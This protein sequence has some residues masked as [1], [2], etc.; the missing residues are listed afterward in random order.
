MISRRA[1]L[2]RHTRFMGMPANLSIAALPGDTDPTATC[3]IAPVNDGRWRE[4]GEAA[5]LSRAIDRVLGHTRRD[6]AG[7]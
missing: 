4:V 6:V 3:G 2:Q 7:R 1:L 5:G